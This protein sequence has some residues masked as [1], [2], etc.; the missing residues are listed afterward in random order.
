MNPKTV[1]ERLASLSPKQQA[2]LHQQLAEKSITSYELIA[3]SLDKLGITHIYAVSGVPIHATLAACS[4]V[5]L[6]I[7]GVRHQQ[8]AVM[9]ALAQN[10]LWL[11]LIK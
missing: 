2:L 4:K 8:A 1:T 7:I 3:L 6:R 5:G 9:M 11:D 10:Q